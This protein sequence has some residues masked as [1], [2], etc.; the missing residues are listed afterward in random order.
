MAGILLLHAARIGL[1][2]GTRLNVVSALWTGKTFRQWGHS[3]L[4]TPEDGFLL[5]VKIGLAKSFVGPR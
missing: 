1:K 4:V 5:Q 2:A 3:L